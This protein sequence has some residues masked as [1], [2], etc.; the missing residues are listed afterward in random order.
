[1]SWI[2]YELG[3]LLWRRVIMDIIGDSYFCFGF[4]FVF[5]D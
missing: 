3:G 1:M 4:D 5:F 2:D